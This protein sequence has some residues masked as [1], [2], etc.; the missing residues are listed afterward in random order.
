MTA[1]FAETFVDLFVAVFAVL[2]VLGTLTT[3]LAA[4]ASRA[5]SEGFR[6]RVLALIIVRMDVCCGCG[7]QFVASNSSK[8]VWKWNKICGI[9]VRVVQ[10]PV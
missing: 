4:V 8:R 9:R 7:E 3:S 1:L 6:L 5:L 10:I 2:L